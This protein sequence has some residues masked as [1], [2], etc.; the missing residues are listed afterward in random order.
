MFHIV[1]LEIKAIYNLNAKKYSSTVHAYVFIFQLM[2]CVLIQCNL[3]KVTK[4][5]HII[6]FEIEPFN[7]SPVTYHRHLTDITK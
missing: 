7:Q 5:Y 4:F 1:F 6:K 2:Q 3:K